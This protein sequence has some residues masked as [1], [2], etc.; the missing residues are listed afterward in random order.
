[1]TDKARIKIA[2]LVTALF[3]AGASTVGIATH[4][5]SPGALPPAPVAV[6]QPAVAAPPPLATAAGEGAYER[7][8]STRGI[9]D[10]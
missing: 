10:D 9:G 5:H 7:E 3:V 4:Q 6:V 8:D 1:M 2:A